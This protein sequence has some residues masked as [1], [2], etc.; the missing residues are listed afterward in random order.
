MIK[1]NST[2]DKYF[3]LELLRENMADYYKQ[4]GIEWN[5]SLFEKSWLEL[6]NLEIISGDRR[7]GVLRLSRDSEVLYI[8]DLQLKKK[9]QN[10]G[11]GSEVTKEVI[12]I[13]KQGNF[14]FVRLRVF[15]INPAQ[16]LYKKLG[17]KLIK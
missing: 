16:N 15:K 7:V 14:E 13:A 10:Q 2:E 12:K 11:I 1:L 3:A 4:L 5:P 9:F 17:F 6:E 8:R